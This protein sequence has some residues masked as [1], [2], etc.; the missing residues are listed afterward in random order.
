MRYVT[1]FSS[2][3]SLN[4]LS[5]YR[6]QNVLCQSKFFE[7]AKKF[8]CIQCLFKNL[9]A[10]TKTYFTDALS[11]YRSQNVVGW[12]D[13][14][15]SDHRFIHILWQSQT[16]CARQKDNLHSVKLVFVPAQKFLKRHYMRSNFWADSKNLDRHKTFWDL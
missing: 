11:F 5:F 16:F 15:V 7:S 3:F 14:F 12:S 9:C 10:G 1:T 13:F 6:S 8:D 2:K 4:A